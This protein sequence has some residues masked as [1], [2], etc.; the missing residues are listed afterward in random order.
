MDE[1]DGTDEVDESKY[2]FMKL[3]QCLLY[4]YVC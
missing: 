2:C 1:C 4:E 3:D